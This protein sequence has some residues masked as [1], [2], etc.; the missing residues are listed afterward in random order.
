MAQDNLAR[1]LA[2]RGQVLPPMPEGFAAWTAEALPVAA[3][4]RGAGAEGLTPLAPQ[5]ERRRA[6]IGLDPL[7][8][9]SPAVASDL[10]A[11]PGA[12]G[13]SRNAITGCHH[14]RLFRHGAQR[15]DALAVTEALSHA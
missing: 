8:R 2:T 12:E 6:G 10:A 4:A 11:A 7:A 5:T 9:V 15:G 13:I 14:G 1:R 3:F